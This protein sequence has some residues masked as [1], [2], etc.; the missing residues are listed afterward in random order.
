MPSKPIRVV[1]LISGRGTNMLALAERTASGELVEVVGVFSNEARAAG[2]DAASERGLYTQIIAHRD[3]AERAQFDDALREA[4]D[5]LV[6]DLVVL[7]G[8]MRILTPPF[9][10][11]YQGRLINIHPSL[12]PNYPGL[13]THERA[14]QDKAKEHGAT[15][16][17][18][19]DELDGGPRIAYAKVAVNTEDSANELAARVLHREHQLLP[20]VV[21]W[22][23][24]GRLALTEQ[25][26][27][28][29]Q[30][31][32][33]TPVEVNN[34]PRRNCHPPIAQT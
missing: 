15:V 32:L 29:D 22:F 3:Y 13:N 26:A 31:L 18:V 34:L 25:G 23:A 9:I 30:H 7:A 21:E 10:N 2:I 8:F 14:L 17:F 20:T 5:R 1:T 11:H 19:T 27:C 6:P 28:L 12:L 33:T 4:I 16:H 24:A